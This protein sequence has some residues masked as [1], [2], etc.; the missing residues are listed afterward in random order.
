MQ[1][2]S[3]SCL[4]RR[5]TRWRCG[6]VA[7]PGALAHC[8][9]DGG[10]DSLD[11]WHRG[12]FH[13]LGSRQWHVRSGDPDDWAVQVVEAFV[14]DDGSDLRAPAAQTRVLFDGEQVACLPN[15]A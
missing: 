12:V 7:I 4:P 14:G 5:A 13:G 9:S 2:Q 8:A 10:D 15:L 6:D 1:G 11:G 3:Y